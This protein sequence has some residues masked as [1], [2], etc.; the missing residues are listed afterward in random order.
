MLE[1][2]V[3]L[4]NLGRGTRNRVHFSGEKVRTYVCRCGVTGLYTAYNVLNR[5]EAVVS[6]DMELVS[7]VY[8]LTSIDLITRPLIRVGKFIC[9]QHPFALTF[10]NTCFLKTDSMKRE[11]KQR[12][13]RMVV[14]GLHVCK[15]AYWVVRCFNQ[16]ESGTSEDSDSE[17]RVVPQPILAPKLSFGSPR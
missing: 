10:S 13:S 17:L 9:L 7:P 12:L 1:G 16:D 14:N 15:C 2:G 4:S 5:L 11:E 6:G 8:I 3:N